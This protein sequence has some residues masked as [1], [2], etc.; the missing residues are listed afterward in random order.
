MILHIF[1]APSL[2]IRKKQMMR[3]ARCGAA[4]WCI[5]TEKVDF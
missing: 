2:Y 3:D 5:H 4:V 1:A